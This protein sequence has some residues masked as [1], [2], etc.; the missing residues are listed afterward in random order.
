[1]KSLNSLIVLVL[2]GLLSVTVQAQARGHGY[3]G[4]H[5]TYQPRFERRVDRR[6]ERQWDRIARGID[7]GELSDREARHLDRQQRKIARMERRF[8]RDGYYSPREKGRM[9]RALDRASR[10]IKRAKHNDRTAYDHRHGGH[11]QYYAYAPEAHVYESY[12]DG[13]APSGASSASIE[14]QTDGFSISW[15]RSKQY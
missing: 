5:D 14:A 2:A 12:D 6:Q 7:S 4:Y 11:Q 10:H 3:A 1:M 8:E 9:E 15:S 13:Y